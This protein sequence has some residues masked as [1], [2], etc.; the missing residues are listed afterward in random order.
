VRHP[1]RGRL[2]VDRLPTSIRTDSD[3][4]RFNH[5]RMRALVADL[6]DHL[7]RA[8]QGGGARP[9][10]RHRAQGKL[11]VRERVETLIDQG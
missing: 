6:R 2:D 9:T 10:E 1:Q 7:G 4:F 5:Q 3:E 8:R 11:P